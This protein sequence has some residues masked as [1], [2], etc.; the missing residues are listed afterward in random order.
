MNTPKKLTQLIESYGVLP[1]KLSEILSENHRYKYFYEDKDQILNIYRFRLQ[2]ATEEG[3][4]F[5]GLDNIVKGLK[6]FNAKII[7]INSFIKVEGKAED[8]VIVT[9]KE[10]SIIIGFML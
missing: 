9:D 1:R 5:E 2:R 7:R 4:T 6:S 10:V 8:F 3:L